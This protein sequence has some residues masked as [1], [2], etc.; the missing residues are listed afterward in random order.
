[1]DSRS[2]IQEFYSGA[3]VLITGGTGFMGKILIDKLL[4]TC[5]TLSHIYLII[6]PKKGKDSDVRLKEL[7]NDP[8]SFSSITFLM[9][10][11]NFPDQT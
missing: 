5:P 10:L 4:R 11:T 6:R 1:M 3:N 9:F 7:F 2:E 8:V